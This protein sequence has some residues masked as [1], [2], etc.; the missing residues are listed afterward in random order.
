MARRDQ[1]GAAREAL[2]IWIRDGVVRPGAPLIVGDIAAELHVSATPVREALSRLAGEGLIEDRRGRGYF[3]HRLEAADLQQVFELH[4]LYVT[5]AFATKPLIDAG[6]LPAPA[7][8]DQ[9]LDDALALRGATEVLFAQIVRRPRNAVLRGRH[10]TIAD[11][12]AFARRIEPLVLEGVWPELQALAVCLNSGDDTAGRSA[13]E[14]YHAR[15]LA[16]A[17]AIVHAAQVADD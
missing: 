10:R 5:G 2:R 14:H 9:P 16:A 17:P 3:V 12:L 6:Q 13:L 4:R 8:D 7:L 1:F 15:R 11:R